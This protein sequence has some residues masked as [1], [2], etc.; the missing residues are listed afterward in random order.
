[1]NE[2]KIVILGAGNIGFSVL[3]QLQNSERN[4][5]IVVIDKRYPSYLKEFIFNEKNN[6]ILFIMADV[7]NQDDLNKIATIDELQKVNILISTIGYLSRSYEFEIFLE[8]FNMNFLGNVVPINRFIK[9]MPRCKNNR[10]IILSSTSGSFA[11]KQVTSYS[12]SKWALES[13]SRSLR[14]ELLKDKIFVDIIRPA[15]I[16][17]KYSNVFKIE[18]GI[19][20]VLV[21]KRI[22]KQLQLTINGKERS[23]GN[24][25]IPRYYF[26]IRICERM[27]PMILNKFYAGLKFGHTRRKNYKYSHHN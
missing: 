15:S 5:K 8:E 19:D 23:G 12:S 11:P 2:K 20:S 7:T 13:F 25:F 24:F 22:Y 26:G 3:Q 4:T 21:A 6:R 27:F 17:N 10:V 16:L 18:K 1:M 9:N 14:C